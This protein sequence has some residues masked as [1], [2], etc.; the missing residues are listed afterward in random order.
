MVINYSGYF[1]SK[2]KS[3]IERAENI[4]LQYF[5]IKMATTLNLISLGEKEICKANKNAFNDYSVTDVITLPIYLDLD[6]IYSEINTDGFVGD[7]LIHRPE[8]RKNALMYG[9]SMT[10]ELELVVIHGMLH[11]F[12]LSHNDEK[13]LIY[14]QDRIIRK[15]WN[16]S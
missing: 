5:K 3:R 9:K 6:D 14:H 15:V 4:F 2:E 13:I 8:I 11:L 1:Y 16:E 7:I 10:D 12:G